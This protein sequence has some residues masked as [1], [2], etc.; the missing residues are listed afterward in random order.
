MCK[1]CTPAGEAGVGKD[2][3][4]QFV[5]QARQSIVHFQI[6]E[7]NGHSVDKEGMMKDCSVGGIRF[8]AREPLGK[9]TR[10]SIKFDSEEW[11]KDLTVV[12][13]DPKH[14]LLDVIGSVMWCLESQENPGEYEI[15]TQFIDEVEQ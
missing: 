4:R 2:D 8:S 11:G 12:Y 3:R 10:I 7:S 5:R 1:R 13:K 6:I 9:N 15:G 14:S